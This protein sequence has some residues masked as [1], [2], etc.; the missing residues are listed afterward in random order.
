M[1]SASAAAGP[2]DS[3]SGR[4]LSPP[5][6]PGW[7]DVAIVT[8]FRER[9]GVPVYLQNDANA[10]RTGG[11][12]ARCRARAFQPCFPH[13]RYRYGRG[14]DFRRTAL[15]RRIRPRRRSWAHP[16]RPLRATRLRKIRV[17]RG[18][19]QRGRHSA[20][21]ALQSVRTA[22]ARQ[23]DRILQKLCRFRQ[24]YGKIR[25]GLRSCRR[26]VRTRNI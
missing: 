7:D 11:V 5:N 14:V 22:P 17:V 15:S 13:L 9:Y 6:L 20:A 23:T 3:R 8:F 19:L 18:L 26:C 2:L 1:P 25:C 24:H 4:I 21:C 10:W 12:E 16:L